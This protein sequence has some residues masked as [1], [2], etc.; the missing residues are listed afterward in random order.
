MDKIMKICIATW[1]V[2]TML[3]PGK[4]NEIMQEL[5]KYNL[6]ITALQEIRWKKSGWFKKGNYAIMHSGNYNNKTVNGTGFLVH[7]DVLP[8]VMGFEPISDRSCK[9]RIKGKFNNITLINV[10]APTEDSEEEEIEEFYSHLSNICDSVSEH[11]SLILLGD[12]NARIGKENE[13]TEIA[14]KHKLHEHTS[15]NGMKLCQLAQSHNSFI[16]STAFQHKQTHKGT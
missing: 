2:C 13:N 9:L 1:N 8:S 15:N 7:K 11:D 4:T 14:G 5:E 3:Q 12:F 16:S 6:K 10:Y